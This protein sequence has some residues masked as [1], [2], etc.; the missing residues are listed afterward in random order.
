MYLN[1][2]NRRHLLIAAAVLISAFLT[3]KS[4]NYFSRAKNFFLKSNYYAA[5]PAN[6]AMCG[7]AFSPAGANLNIP[8]LKGWGH[9]SWKISTSSDSVQF[10]FNQGLSMYYSFHSI[11]AIASFTKATRIDPTCAMAWYGRALAMGPTINYSNG[12]KPPADAF[13]S[14]VKSKQL[15]AKCSPLEKDLISAIQQRYAKD[16]NV[17]VQQLRAKYANAMQKISEKYK[18]NA[19]VL[20]LY[21]DALLLLHPWDLYNHDFRPK[22][23][24]PKIRLLLERAIAISPSHPGANHF[25]IHTMEASA[26]PQLALHSANLL[27]TLMPQVSHI[28][29]MPSHIYIRTGYYQ[30]GIQVNEAGI[31]GFKKYRAQYA[32][33]KNGFFLYEAHNLQLISNCAQMA[34]NFKAAMDAAKAVQS[35]ITQKYLHLK[36]ADGNS[37][38]LIYAMPTLVDV[39]FGKWDSILK[40]PA[41]SGLPYFSVLYHFSRGLAYSR[42]HNFA[43]AKLELEMLNTQLTNKTL[44]WR[45][46][47]FNRAYDGAAIASLILQGVFAEEEN[48]YEAA[49]Q[50][51]QKAV[52]AEDLLIY[53]EPRDWPLPTRHYLANALIKAGKM[54]EAIAVLNK[55]LQINP[56]NGWALTGLKIAMQQKRTANDFTPVDQQLSLAWRTKDTQIVRPVF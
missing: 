33:V 46:E 13:E 15:A 34:G 50:L 56:N 45:L 36:S 27:D 51:L 24:T 49:I 3:A 48:N 22:P 41:L 14:A 16:R 52:Q 29:H 4:F 35:K 55:D 28:T 25:Y 39:R 30:R 31:A 40:R 54:K 1:Y 8:A 53:N 5:L 12:Y 26:T 23:W 7:P 47:H 6:L 38:Q 20:T 42:I 43:S 32:P 10:Y 21:A 44:K 19:E 17:D 11:E 37:A 9:Y 2:M 18:D